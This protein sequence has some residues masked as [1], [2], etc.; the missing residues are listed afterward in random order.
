MRRIFNKE[1]RK[2]NNMKKSTLSERLIDPEEEIVS[3]RREVE[4]EMTEPEA[5]PKSALAKTPVSSHDEDG[6]GWDFIIMIPDPEYVKLQA[7]DGVVDVDPAFVP[8]NEIVERLIIAGLETYQYRTG[9]EDEIVVKVRAPLSKL[10]SHATS[11]KFIMK[12]DEHYLQDVIDDPN[13]PIVDDIE[14]TS[15][16]PYEYIYGPYDQGERVFIDNI[17]LF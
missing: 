10:K 9:D 8:H 17:F 12:Y 1:K 5:L 7:P 6:Y 11:L 14:V 4:I 15:Y 2:K 13:K 16:S 3:P